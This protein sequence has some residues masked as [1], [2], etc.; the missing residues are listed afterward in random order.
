MVANE[1]VFLKSFPVDF[2]IFSAF[3]NSGRASFGNDDGL[4]FGKSPK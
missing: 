2:D 1:S 3:D 4:E